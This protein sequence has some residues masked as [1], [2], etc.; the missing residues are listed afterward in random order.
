ME[1][2]FFE[3]FAEHAA[4]HGLEKALR[5]FSKRIQQDEL[6]EYEREYRARIENVRL[7]YPPKIISAPGITPWYAG[8]LDVDRYWPP[9]RTY[10]EETVDWPIDPLDESS[11]KV[12]AY[13][14]DPSQRSFSTKGLVVGYVQSGKTTNFTAV[15][16]KA[17]D[18][19]YRLIVVLSGIHNGLRRQTQER[20]Q[21]QLLERRQDAWFPLT[22]PERDFQVQTVNAQAYL[23]QRGTGTVICV[24]KKNQRVL[25]KLRRW[26]AQA[27][28]AGALENVP[29]LVIDDEADQAS[30]ATPKINPEI[31]GILE[32]FPRRTYIGYTATP[33]ANV[34]IDPSSVDLYPETFILN[35]PQPSEGYFGTEKV[36]GRDAVEGD[37]AGADLDGYDMVRIVPE[38][39][40]DLLR[41]K[42]RGTES[43]FVP[44]IT[45]ELRR[46]V[47]YFWLATAVR[48]V[49]G[50]DGHSTMLI[51]TSMKTTVHEAYKEPLY[52]LRKSVL[53]G[54]RQGA[55]YVLDEL[56]DIWLSETGRVKPE[57]FDNKPVSFDD[58][59]GHLPAVIE[60]TRVI[61]DNYRSR[62]RLDYSGEPVVAIAVGGNTLSR[63]LTLEGLVVSFF[64][65]AAKTYDT[66]LQMGRWFGFRGGYEDLPRIWMTDQLRS[67][68][69]H[70]ATVEH[71]IRLDIERYEEQNISPKDLGVRIRTHPVLNVTTK[72]GA[73]RIAYASYGGRRVQ[74]RY[75]RETDS[76]WLVQNLDAAKSL[77]ANA[78]TDGASVDGGTDGRYLLREVDVKHIL[79]FLDTYQV[80]ED[81]PDLDPRLVRAYIEKES[82]RN[83]PSLLSWNVAIMGA[84]VDD[85]SYDDRVAFTPDLTV[86]TINRSKLKDSGG[87]KADIKTL[88]S[89]EDRVV[90]LDISASEAR[91]KSEGALV[92]LR[93]A[94]PVQ[95]NRGL[96]LLYPIRKNSQPDPQ[97]R[98]MRQ[99][100]EASHHVIGLALVFPGNAEDKVENR[101]VQ[102]DTSNLEVDASEYEEVEAALTA[103]DAADVDGDG[104]RH[105]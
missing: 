58:L 79:G 105:G 103:D 5:T 46:S 87:T 71:E 7:G 99:P 74:T 101:Y 75:F 33:F 41:P 90:D 30:V 72:M 57:W 64:V 95:A 47:L 3:V 56:R 59:L 21:K 16:A 2:D 76:D 6:A 86:G 8:P 70:L 62:D 26:L 77:V 37:A 50:D 10:L 25:A 68:F 69:R 28:R 78:V 13:T 44:E 45:D 83:P 65:R 91:R 36:F 52:D 4:R 92:D 11:S 60:R 104:S 89:K 97:N 48:R 22:T 53:N 67:W 54:V 81:S 49:R 94:D 61:L 14:L 43:G 1:L 20:L 93:N 100:L 82:R 35:L 15:I 23:Q 96:L 42:G 66:L 51:H 27:A 88:M 55:D 38:D 80:H 63:G 102:V 73:A 17:A 98:E 31:R 85:L 40:V 9:F 24:V 18:V 84:A 39:T 12:I 29:V 19:G 32:L 34:L